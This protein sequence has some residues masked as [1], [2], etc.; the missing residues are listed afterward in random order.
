VEQF[1]RR[2]CKLKNHKTSKVEQVRKRR[3]YNQRN[4]MTLK[5][6]VKKRKKPQKIHE[7]EKVEAIPT[8]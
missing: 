2:K 1:K 6:G 8:T 5:E 4:H 7:H 3:M